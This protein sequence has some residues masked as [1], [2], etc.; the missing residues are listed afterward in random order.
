MIMN[1]AVNKYITKAIIHLYDVLI[2][3]SNEL[4]TVNDL[5]WASHRRID[6]LPRKID[7]LLSLRFKLREIVEIYTNIII[8]PPIKIKNSI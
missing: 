6:V 2:I 8:I 1:I 4:F 7:I 5:I 3:M